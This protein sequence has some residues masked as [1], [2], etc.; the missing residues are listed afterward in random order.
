MHLTYFLVIILCTEN[1]KNKNILDSIYFKNFERF[2]EGRHCLLNK[3]LL[4]EFLG[5]EPFATEKIELL[6]DI[7]RTT[8]SILKFE[9]YNLIKPILM[10]TSVLHC[11]CNNLSLKSIL[12]A[13]FTSRLKDF[14]LLSDIKYKAAFIS[15]GTRYYQPITLITKNKT[16]MKIIKAI[17]EKI[18]AKKDNFFKTLKSQS[19]ILDGNL[20]YELFYII[21]LAEQTLSRYS[22][23]E[24]SN[25]YENFLNSKFIE[26]VFKIQQ[27]NNFPIHAFLLFD[28]K[29]DKLDR[30]NFNCFEEALDINFLNNCIDYDSFTD[31]I[32]FSSFINSTENF[33]I[34]CDATIILSFEYANLFLGLMQCYS[35]HLKRNILLRVEKHYNDQVNV[36]FIICNEMEYVKTIKEYYVRAYK[37]ASDV[38]AEIETLVKTDKL[39]EFT[40]LL[41]LNTYSFKPNGTKGIDG[42]FYWLNCG[43]FLGFELIDDFLTKLDHNCHLCRKLVG[44]KIC[45]QHK[46][47]KAL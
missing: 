7:C 1:I 39:H 42:W 19:L 34:F 4:L 36:K 43:H 35:K 22:T 32:N 8:Y 23:S 20:I 14:C 11:N 10:N 31:G 40:T 6:F 12:I 45:F 38:S 26:T 33:D 37:S 5:D 2:I 18:Y 47:Y 21:S 15:Y 9:K 24:Q 29:E 16:N 46:A 3:K 41:D 30:I 28:K 13:T 25:L 27:N 17:T 44:I